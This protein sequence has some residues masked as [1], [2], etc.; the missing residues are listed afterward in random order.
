MITMKKEYPETKSFDDIWPIYQKGG[1]LH[2]STLDG[3]QPRVRIMSFT[4]LDKKIWVV[5]RS[6]DDK[7]QQLRKNP[8]IEFTY[9]YQGE[10]NIGCLRASGT[11]IIVDDPAIRA[12][13]TKAIPWFN[14]YWESSEDPNFTLIRL[15]IS[16]ILFDPA[17]ERTKYTVIVK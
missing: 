6:G 8:N 4:P 1:L 5:T 7:I 10:Q 16:K 9:S 3:N 17:N 12:R 11:A 14:G 13:V 15:D 2:L